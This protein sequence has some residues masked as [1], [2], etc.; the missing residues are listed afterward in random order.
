LAKGEGHLIIYLSKKKK[1]GIILENFTTRN[2]PK[3]DPRNRG[4][5]E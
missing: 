1:Y 5:L 3:R 4:N 2:M